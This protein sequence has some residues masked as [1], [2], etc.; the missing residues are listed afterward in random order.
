MT[1]RLDLGAALVA[2]L[3]EETVAQLAERLRP[4]L[5]APE[6]A[7]RLITAREAG[8]RLG[9]HPKTITRMA[10]A[11]RL[12]AVKVGRSWRFPAGQLV[13]AVPPSPLHANSSRPRRS[14]EPGPV[15]SVRA[16]RGGA[17]AS[18]RKVA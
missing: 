12:H 3:D 10:R 15:A 2:A 5:D 6:V 18:T 11:G 16:I 14:V 4:H 7:D 8:E 1:G 9:L 13:V 17:S